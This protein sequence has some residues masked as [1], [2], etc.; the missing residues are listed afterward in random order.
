MGG[1]RVSA[2]TSGLLSTFTW[3]DHSE[4]QRRQILEAIDL[5]REKDTRDELG[6][7]GI[8]DTFSDMLFPGTGALQTRARYFLFVPW[9]Y[10]DFEAKRVPS[11]EAARRVR[12]VEVK[13]I[14]TLAESSTPPP[15][16]TIGIQARGGLQRFP[17]S[18]YW[19]GL[20]VLG[21]C[22]FAGSQAEYQ[23]NFDRVRA[24]GGTVRRNDDGEVIGGAARAWHGGLPPIPPTFP[25]QA[26]FD[27]T[28]A[29]AR[30][31]KSRV[32]ENHRRSLFAYMLDRDYVDAENG[33]AWEHA[34]VEGASP[35][36]LR[37]ISHARCFSEVMNGAAILYNLY[38]AEM[39]PRREEV[40]ESCIELLDDWLA[41]MSA[42]RQ[43]L[44]AWDRMDFWK[45]LEARTYIPRGTTRPFVEEWCNRT[46]SGD[47]ASL[48]DAANTKELISRREAQIKGP[49]ARFNNRRS[50][51]MWRGDAGLGRLDFRWSNA[52]VILSDI[53]DGLGGASA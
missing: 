30:Y 13:L 6:I 8:R 39:D 17:S 31:L 29:E 25:S 40:I 26:V 49:L 27:L 20:K 51:E 11:A 38:L 33:F 21:I 24:A 36:L 10:L 12:D 7:A 3:I 43:Q 44:L 41:L 45:L 9:M 46:L 22:L 1:R 53:A 47:P 5:F 15:R 2:Y 28:A 16:G 50:R 52:R 48:R 4:K 18:I 34:S 23:R 42:R 14:D 35:E 19:N 32:L 37:E